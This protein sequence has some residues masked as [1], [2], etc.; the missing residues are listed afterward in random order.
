MGY[1][2]VLWTGNTELYKWVPRIRGWS[3]SPWVS[4]RDTQALSGHT[5]RK[6][7][8]VLLCWQ[9]LLLCW[10]PLY[11]SAV[12][13][14]SLKLPLLVVTF[15]LMAFMGRKNPRTLF[16]AKQVQNSP[17]QPTKGRSGET[18]GQQL[19]LLIATQLRNVLKAFRL[20]LC[21]SQK[22]PLKDQLNKHPVSASE[23]TS[24]R[25]H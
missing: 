18:L 25:A 5:C 13:N 22:S 7:P 12:A 19:T 24:Q 21:F 3:C 15:P 9:Q 17:F 8:K 10:C 23:G 1:W 20:S 4:N 14:I 2:D 16:Q 6:M 11:N